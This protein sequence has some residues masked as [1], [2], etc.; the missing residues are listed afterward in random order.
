MDGTA[1]PSWPASFPTF[2]ILVFNIDLE[3]AKRLISLTH[4]I[5]DQKE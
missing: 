1:D 2:S 4:K 3:M 5:I